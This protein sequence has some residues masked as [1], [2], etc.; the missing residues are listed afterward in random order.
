VSVET[1]IYTALAA[2]IA[3]AAEGEAL[4]AAELHNTI[5]EPITKPFGLRVGDTNCDLAP[6]PG[7]P[8]EEWDVL[9]MVQIFALVNGDTAEAQIAAREKVRALGLKTA[10]VLL[11]DTTLGHT[12][13]DSR[14]LGGERGW[15]NVQ[16]SR[17]AAAHLHLIANETGAY[18]K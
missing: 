7:G 3:A 12:V 17:Y 1:A 6:G 14:I 15:A 5:Y 11:A 8:V 2:A 9:G 13:N 16:G 10:E 4:F 18:Q